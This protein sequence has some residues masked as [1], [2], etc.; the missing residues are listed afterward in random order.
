V[1]NL[2][3]LVAGVSRVNSHQFERFTSI[4]TPGHLFVIKELITVRGSVFDDYLLGEG[5]HVAKAKARTC[6]I[7]GDYL[8]LSPVE[9]N[10]NFEFTTI[11]N[12]CIV[13]QDICFLLGVAIEE[14]GFSV[15]N[16]VLS[17]WGGVE[18]DVSDLGDL[19][20]EMGEGSIEL[21][22]LSES[23]TSDQIVVTSRAF[24]FQLHLLIFGI[25]GNL[26]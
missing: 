17:G 3:V 1:K 21:V 24:T 14:F 19:L 26:E 15:E 6:A 11:D 7:S 10:I 8:S 23:V 4:I 5:D 9:C 2:L 18:G 20:S 25:L 13:T 12:Y 16:G 22:L